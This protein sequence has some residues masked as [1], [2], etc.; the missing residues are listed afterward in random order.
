MYFKIEKLTTFIQQQLQALADPAKAGPMAAYLKTDMPFYGVQK[1][2]RVPI[3]KEMKKRFRPQSQEDYE[4]AVLALWSLPH[5]EEKYTAITFALQNE[6]FITT[7]SLPL[8]EGLIREGAWWDLVDGVASD[9]V[10]RVLLEHRSQTRAA[11]EKWVDDPDLWIRRTA[12]IA[13]LR[14]KEQTD[15]GQLFD[16][17]LRRA[18]EKEFFIRKAIGWALREYSKTAPVEVR[19]FL[20][21]NRE[22]LSGLSFREGA[23]RLVKAGLM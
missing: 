4:C 8:Y 7:K 19:E 1:P 16:H 6:A 5:R 3:Y 20:L 14:H 22:I 13:H 11:I 15:A 2:D 21:K 18:H 23:K 10:G 17:C 9:L 12:I